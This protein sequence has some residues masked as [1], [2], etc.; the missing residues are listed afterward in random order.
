M[1][2][3][4]VTL[5]WDSFWLQHLREA[6]SWLAV[7]GSRQRYWVYLTES[8]VEQWSASIAECGS[9]TSYQTTWRQVSHG[10]CR[11]EGPNQLETGKAN[12]RK[13]SSALVLQ[14]KRLSV[15]MVKRASKLQTARTWGV[16]CFVLWDDNI[17]V[18]V[19]WISSM[20]QW[21]LDEKNIPWLTLDPWGPLPGSTVHWENHW[22]FRSHNQALGPA[23]CH[24]WPT[25]TL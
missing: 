4:L 10:I 16:F 11:R 19:I 3:R 23:A 20:S 6:R 17:R 25:K 7:N 12:P 9:W 15:Q 22:C 24:P 14:T 2:F 1:N 8:L 5:T 21:L 18:N 13:R